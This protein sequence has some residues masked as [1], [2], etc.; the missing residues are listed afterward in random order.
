MA[1]GSVGALHANLGITVDPFVSGM[2]RALDST[3]TMDKGLKTLSGSMLLASHASSVFGIAGG[4]MAS[5]LQVGIAA[6]AHITTAIRGLDK[7][8]KSVLL[9]TGIGVGIV[10][11]GFAI[12]RIAAYFQRASESAKKF[13]EDVQRATK[14]LSTF[15]METFKLQ[16]GFKLG[17]ANGPDEKAR[18]ELAVSRLDMDSKILAEQKS[19]AETKRLIDDSKFTSVR[20]E[21][22]MQELAWNKLTDI[23]GGPPSKNRSFDLS[24]GKYAVMYSNAVK[25][26]A[27]GGSLYERENELSNLELQRREQERRI[28]ILQ[29]ER[30]AID[31]RATY[32]QRKRYGALMPDEAEAELLLKDTELKDAS[33]RRLQ[34]LKAIRALQLGGMAGAAKRLFLDEFG[35]TLDDVH[36]ERGR[37]ARIRFSPLAGIE[38]LSQTATFGEQRLDRQEETNRLLKENNKYTKEER[39]FLRVISGG[40]TTGS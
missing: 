31:T 5:Q 6:I 2:R 12:E 34:D 4:G 21:R 11:V 35:D 23:Y 32:E 36:Q 14:D 8:L 18:S 29:T 25:R 38:R 19:L 13:G 40:L 17:A 26:L 39:D 33:S 1:S 27:P 28:S 20:N 10:A 24:F 9:A 22:A 16:A 7:G 37:G 15:G 30:S 3:K